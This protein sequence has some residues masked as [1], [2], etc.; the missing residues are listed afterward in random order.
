MWYFIF[1]SCAKEYPHNSS[2]SCAKNIN[3]YVSFFKLLEYELQL[4]ANHLVSAGPKLYY[5]IVK[6]TLYFCFSS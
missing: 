5:N 4:F 3:K 1:L 2:L 6:G